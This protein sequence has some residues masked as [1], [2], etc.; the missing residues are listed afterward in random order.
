MVKR[1]KKKIV[2]N[3]FVM[4]CTHCGPK[5]YLCSFLLDWVDYL[6]YMPVDFLSFVQFI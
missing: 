3:N 4:M 2:F 5:V 1:W 6:Y